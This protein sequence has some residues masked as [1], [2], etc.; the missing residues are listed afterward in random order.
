M[1]W[2]SHDER[3]TPI[4]VQQGEIVAYANNCKVPIPHKT[5][6]IRAEAY[7][8][9]NRRKTMGKEIVVLNVG[10][11]RRYPNDHNM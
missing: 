10:N 3:P 8:T 9:S 2:H 11:D 1:P 4:F 6:D 7:G 5:G